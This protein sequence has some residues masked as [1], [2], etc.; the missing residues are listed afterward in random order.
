LHRSSTE[1]CAER[2]A[3]IEDSGKSLFGKHAYMTC[4]SMANCFVF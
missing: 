1:V 2:V 3:L 4:F